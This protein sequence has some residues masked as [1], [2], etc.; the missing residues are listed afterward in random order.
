M[1]IEALALA[2]GMSVSTIHTVLHNNLGL[3]K[4]SAMGPQ[5]FECRAEAA[6]CRD[7]FRVRQSCPPPL[8]R[9]AGLDC[10][11]GRDD[12]VVLHASEQETVPAVN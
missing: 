11:D 3:E 8:S 4:K 9:H 12:S 5:T 1:C 2:H 6:A 10:D 7:L